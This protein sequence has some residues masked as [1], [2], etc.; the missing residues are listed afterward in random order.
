ISDS[1]AGGSK[2]WRVLMFRHMRRRL[3]A[4]R[5]ALAPCPLAGPPR[6]ARER[7]SVDSVPPP[8][9]PSTSFRHQKARGAP[10][11]APL[12][13]TTI[14]ALST[15]HAGGTTPGAQETAVS[16]VGLR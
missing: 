13:V 16:R 1:L 5:R 2:L 4:Q 15:I 7:N 10:L 8:G 12:A 14:S 6:R 11:T 3:T 9:T